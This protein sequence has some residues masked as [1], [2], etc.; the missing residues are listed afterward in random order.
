MG[1]FQQLSIFKVINFQYE[2]G[3]IE[4]LFNILKIATNKN[5]IIVFI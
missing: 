4:N 5:L 2:K 1:L 3:N